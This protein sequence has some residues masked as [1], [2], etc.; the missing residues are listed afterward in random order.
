MYMLSFW[1]RVGSTTPLRVLT[2][3]LKSSVNHAGGL[4]S[5][6]HL[7]FERSDIRSIGHS[8]NLN[9]HDHTKVGG[10]GYLAV[11]VSHATVTQSIE[12]S[13]NDKMLI[14]CVEV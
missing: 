4:L 14:F 1:L 12:P 11:Y 3:W 6:S 7:I 10:N 5:S 8:V 2:Q 13:S 9:I